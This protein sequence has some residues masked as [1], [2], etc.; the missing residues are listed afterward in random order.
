MRRVFPQHRPD[1]R[2]DPVQSVIDSRSRRLRL[3]NNRFRKRKTKKPYLLQVGHSGLRP[4]SPTSFLKQA[5]AE[6]ASHHQLVQESRTNPLSLVQDPCTVKF[7]TVFR[8]AQKKTSCQIK[9]KTAMHRYRMDLINCCVTQ[10][11]STQR[12]FGGQ[13]AKQHQPLSTATQARSQ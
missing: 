11:R 3:A 9:A 7:I 10:N 5:V 1:L 6:T 12:P 13:N 2:K 8:V 4:C